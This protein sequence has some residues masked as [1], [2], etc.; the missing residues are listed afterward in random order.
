M[1]DTNINQ[2]QESV[3]DIRQ[4][5]FSLLR[6]ATLFRWIGYGLLIFSVFDTIAVFI[7][8]QLLNPSWEF[9]TIGQLVERVPVPLIG[10]VL[11]FYGEKL[12]RKKWEIPLVKLLSWFTVLLALV[13]FLLAPL[14]IV[15]TIR[16]NNRSTAQI[17][18]EMNQ[19][20]EQIT[21]VKDLLVKADTPQEM[22]ELISR[23]DT[24]GRTPTIADSQQVDEIRAQ[25]SEVIKQ[26]EETM[27]TQASEAKSNRRIALFKNSVKWNLGALVAGAL[28]LF[29]FIGTGWAR[30]M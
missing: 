7:P 23:L 15:N 27:Q 14:G 16:L 9:Q 11:V 12:G 25:V 19:R 18:G 1:S 29:L 3:E 13:F 28:F 2:L 6:S 20:M 5:G 8:P 10:M 30:K 17:D 24:Q 4:F 21:Q 22:Q 26:A